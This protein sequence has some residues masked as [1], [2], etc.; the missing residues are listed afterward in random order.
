MAN[1]QIKN[2]PE[3]LHGELRRRAKARKMT[4]RDY[5]LELIERDRVRSSMQEW[6]DELA[7]QPPLAPDLKPGEVAKWIDEEWEER[8]A[9]IDRGPGLVGDHRSARQA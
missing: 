4:V 1:L 3:D 5:V 6:L 7:S 8:D 9:A 2:V